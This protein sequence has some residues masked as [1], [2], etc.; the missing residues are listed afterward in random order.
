MVLLQI[1]QSKT[2]PIGQG[3]VV[4]VGLTGQDICPV[5][6][7]LPYLVARGAQPSSSHNR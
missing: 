1:K 7:L 6:A 3:N 4:S 2:N 5:K